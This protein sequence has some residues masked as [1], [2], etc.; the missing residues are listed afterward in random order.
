MLDILS[1][2]DEWLRQQKRVALATVVE[3]W[4]SAPRRVGSKMAVAQDMAMVG[5]VSGGCV[6]GA[7]IEEALVALEDNQPRLLHYGVSDDDAWE[8][9]LACGGKISIW[10]EPLDVRWW[11][12][13][14]DAARHDQP[15]TTLTVLEGDAAGAKIAYSADDQI[16]Y[17][18]DRVS[19]EQAQAFA[20]VMPHM[21]SG[22]ATVAAQAVMVDNIM[23]R[24]HSVMIGGVHMRRR[25]SISPGRSASLVTLIDPRDA[26]ATDERFP[27]VDCIFHSYPDK[28]LAQISIDANTYIAVLTHDPKIDDRAL[29]A[30]LAAQPAY[31]GVLSSRRTHE[32]R[33]E[34][35][36]GAGIALSELERLHTPIG[37]SIGAATPEEI[38]LAIMA[39]VVAVK[40]RK[41]AAQPV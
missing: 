30:A 34:R 8:V 37:L 19:S 20:A 7:V 27:D 14:E 32:K 40:N 21:P 11:R 16:V 13:A 1:Q 22:R 31:I 6:E 4:G 15:L 26:F 2:V 29:K 9:G 3:T 28:A 36:T 39:E 12:L 24:P 17:T 33:I 10:V 41:A 18:N 38:A 25:C 5:S 23:P 35:L